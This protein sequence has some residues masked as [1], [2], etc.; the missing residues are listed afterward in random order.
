M[1]A[2]RILRADHKANNIDGFA[3]L[4][5]EI[6]WLCQ[7]GDDAHGTRQI[8]MHGMWNRNTASNGGAAKTFAAHHNFKKTALAKASQFGGAFSKLFNNLLFAAS[9]DANQNLVG[10]EIINYGHEKTRRMNVA[11]AASFQG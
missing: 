9:S 8:V 2:I 3:I 10:G 7:N 1:I 6:N 4:C 11:R 5:V